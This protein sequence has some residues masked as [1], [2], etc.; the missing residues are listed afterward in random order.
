MPTHQRKNETDD[1]FKARLRS[2]SKSYYW[3]HRKDQLAKSR[4]WK[5]ANYEYRLEYQR[6]YARTNRDRMAENHRRWRAANWE[7]DQATRVAYATKNKQVLKVA[8][9]LG[10]SVGEARKQLETYT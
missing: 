2:Y 1:E 6:R 4:E 3:R 9:A 7:R 5:T 10:I 8:R